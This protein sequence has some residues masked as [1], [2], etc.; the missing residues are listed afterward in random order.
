MSNKI[1]KVITH[2][3]EVPLLNEWKI[4]LYAANTR[5]HAIV[6]LITEDGVHGFGEASP[7]PAFMGETADT[8]KLVIDKYLTPVIIGLKVNDLALIHE[9]MNKAIYSN[10]AAKSAVD[11]AAYDSWAKTMNVPVYD[12]IGGAYRSEVPLTYV[13]GIK[14]N[15]NAY[16]EALM[17]INDGYTVIKVKI[18]REPIRD[19]ALV[20]LIRKAI[21]D[22]GK[23]VKVRLDVNQGYDVSTSIKVI[24]ELEKTGAIES[25]EQPVKKWNIFGIKE[26]RDK[27]NTPIMIDETV[28]GIE[29]A[30]NAIK[31][32]IA[33]IINLKICKVGGLYQSKKIASMAEAS[34]MSCTVGSNL[35][36]GIGIAASLHFVASTPVVNKP[37]DFICGLYL[38]QYDLIDNSL[39]DLIDNGRM[40]LLTSPGLGVELKKEILQYT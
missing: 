36:L 38:H 34:G 7:S 30:I 1:V 13:I 21:D 5:R 18:G 26:I 39:F 19:I 12:L 11:I 16:E 14:E 8:I 25:I 29:D 31:L 24:R 32:G 35:E 9:K 3:I 15:I 22:S 27:V 2:I 6:E 28:F 40:K 17:L 4:A 10:S 33:D 23:D 20:N 37:S